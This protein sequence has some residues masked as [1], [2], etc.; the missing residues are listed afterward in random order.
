MG[1]PH[2]DSQAKPVLYEVKVNYDFFNYVVNQNK[3]YLVGTARAAAS[4]GDVRLPARTS[5]ASM[6]PGAGTQGKQGG[7]KG[8]NPGPKN[9]SAQDCL[10]STSD[11]PCLAGSV[12]LKA[13]WIDL[14]GADS[15][16]RAKYHIAKVQHYLINDKFTGN[17]CKEPATYG[18]IGLHIIQRIHHNKGNPGGSKSASGSPRGGTDIFATWEHTDNDSAGFTY[19]N[20]SPAPPTG[21]ASKPMPYPNIA[22][23]NVV[24]R[25]AGRRHPG[26]CTGPRGPGP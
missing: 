25:Y 8:P 22:E 10:A 21:S 15:A 16:T 3:Y 13:A 11:L 4:T 23:A 24:R 12:H 6:P 14:T 19:A 26:A 2:G 20:Y 7:P 9:Y 5:A 1:D 18:L 17:I